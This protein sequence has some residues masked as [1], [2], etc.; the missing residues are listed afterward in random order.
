MDDK[1][2]SI[3]FNELNQSRK[4]IQ[5]KYSAYEQMLNTVDLAIHTIRTLKQGDLS[6]WL[7]RLEQQTVYIK[8]LESLNPISDNKKVHLNSAYLVKSDIENKISSLTLYAERYHIID[9]VSGFYL[10]RNKSWIKDSINAGI[11]TKEETEYYT[12]KFYKD[13]EL[14]FNELNKALTQN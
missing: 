6:F 14:L 10:T 5:N 8:K 12:K 3:V 2:I 1:E 9:K 7:N 4:T 11:Y 13:K